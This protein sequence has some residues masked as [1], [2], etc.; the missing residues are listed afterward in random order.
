MNNTTS[1]VL[2]LT[3]QQGLLTL[4]NRFAYSLRGKIKK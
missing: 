1:K 3:E 2:D 4:F